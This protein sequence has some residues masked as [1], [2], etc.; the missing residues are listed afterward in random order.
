MKK[1]ISSALAGVLSILMLTACGSVPENTV[2]SVDDL[3]GKVI[4]VQLGTTG[5][6]YAEDVKDATVEKYNKGADAI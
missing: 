2:N 4:G 3:E 5:D 1:I 6:I